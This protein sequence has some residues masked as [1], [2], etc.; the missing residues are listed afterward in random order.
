MKYDLASRVPDPPQEDET[1]SE[2]IRKWTLTTSVAVFAVAALLAAIHLFAPEARAQTPS[3]AV[4]CTMA[5]SGKVVPGW[6]A[7]MTEQISLGRT[8]FVP[9]MASSGTFNFSNMCAW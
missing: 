2:T 1:M 4:V 5:P 8:H 3:Q 9:F 6:E 7:W